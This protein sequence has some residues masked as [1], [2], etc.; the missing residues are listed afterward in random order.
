M[1]YIQ[2]ERALDDC[3]QYCFYLAD[4]G[5][6]HLFIFYLTNNQGFSML[7]VKF[8]CMWPCALCEY[9][10]VIGHCLLTEHECSCSVCVTCFMLYEKKT[11]SHTDIANVKRGQSFF[12][13]IKGRFICCC[14]INMPDQIRQKKST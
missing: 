10:P 9:Q 14:N 8:M 2:R 1:N 12:F 13:I 4:M 7:A 6:R 5:H 3:F 11:K